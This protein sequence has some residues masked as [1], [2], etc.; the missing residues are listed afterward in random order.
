MKSKDYYN[1]TKVFYRLMCINLPFTN[2]SI[3]RRIS[4]LKEK[5]LL[6]WYIK[7]IHTAVIAQ[8]LCILLS[9]IIG[10]LGKRWVGRVKEVRV[11]GTRTKV[12]KYL[13]I[14]VK[15]F[16]TFSKILIKCEWEKFC[17]QI[18]KWFTPIIKG[19][20]VTYSNSS[21][22]LWKERICHWNNTCEKWWEKFCISCGKNS[23]R[24]H[25]SFTAASKDAFMIANTSIYSN[26]LSILEPQG[27]QEI[28]LTHCHKQMKENL[29]I[30]QTNR[31]LNTWS[32]NKLQG[33]HWMW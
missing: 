20:K 6:H 14:W 33:I 29:L 27:L 23:K 1:F 21:L 22:K 5:K 4:F 9:L 25:K 24:Y 8:N 26:L 15:L 11:N 32:A 13:N 19:K 7:S 17:L 16:W 2:I 18:G 3:F 31:L 12:L 28:C 10:M 30:V